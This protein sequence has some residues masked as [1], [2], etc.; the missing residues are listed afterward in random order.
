MN[1]KREEDHYLKQYKL[2]FSQLFFMLFKIAISTLAHF[3]FKVDLSFQFE[4]FLRA[5]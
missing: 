3:H 1:M 2:S 4:K 5:S